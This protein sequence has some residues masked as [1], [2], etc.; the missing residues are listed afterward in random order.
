MTKNMNIFN[1]NEK[2]NTVKLKSL[3]NCQKLLPKMCCQKNPNVSILTKC[4]NYIN[5]RLSVDYILNR[6]YVN[7]K[8]MKYVLD[9]NMHK[10]MLKDISQ[11]IPFCILDMN[12]NKDDQS[13]NKKYMRT[14]FNS[15]KELFSNISRSEVQLKTVPKV[16]I[17]KNDKSLV[18]E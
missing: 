13:F 5:T 12:L 15:G 10:E 11:K 18:L 7:E 14:N 9:E 17:P 2:D 4:E 1:T 3:T 16:Y 8:F 6:F